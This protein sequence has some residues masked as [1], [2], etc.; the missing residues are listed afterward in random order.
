[1]TKRIINWTHPEVVQLFDNYLHDPKQ[2]SLQDLATEVTVILGCDV[3]KS[4]IQSRITSIRKSRNTLVKNHASIQPEPNE[5]TEAQ[6]LLEN[7]QNLKSK[8]QEALTEFEDRTGITCN[9]P[10][11]PQQF[12]DSTEYVEVEVKQCL[13]KFLNDSMNHK[14][15]V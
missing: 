7:Y 9:F 4:N 5:V 2:K 1:M 12:S 15:R 6:N 10:T 3:T 8:I 13:N 11:L 14:T